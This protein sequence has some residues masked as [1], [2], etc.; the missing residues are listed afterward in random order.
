[1]SAARF[2]T[3]STMQDSFQNWSGVHFSKSMRPQSAYEPKQWMQPISTT[4]REAFQQWA[5]PKR[6]AF[7]PA[8]TREAA[9]DAP[10][11]RSTMQDS[12]LPISR[13]VPTKSA[14]PVERALEYTPFDGTTTSRQAYQP[15]PLP[16]RHG[17]KKPAENT[18]M[19]G[20]DNMPFP[21]STYRD[22]FRE[23]RVPNP[24]AHAVGLQVVGGKFHEVLKKGTR[25]PCT[26]KMLM[27]TTTDRQTKVDIVV[28]LTSD[29]AQKKGRVLGEFE[30]DGIAPS[31]AG[32]PQVEV[33]FV[34][35]NDASLR[36]SANDVQG[37]RTRA[38]S[39]KEK[40][41]LG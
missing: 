12:Y 41:R 23:I 3:R 6:Q 19:G 30:L 39:V 29:D 13:F 5:A 4:H 8:Q 16:P 31:R 20:G 14:Q 34:L 21:N 40:V 36:V 22:M 2:D 33:T 38:L 11:G 24:S 37:Q 28:V 18:W 10:T 25:A 32:V 7:K 17:R 35:S 9:P 27:T 1:M 26:K 15:W